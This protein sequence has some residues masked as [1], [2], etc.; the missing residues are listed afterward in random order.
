MECGIIS[1]SVPDG[2][3]GTKTVKGWQEEIG[4]LF[5]NYDNNIN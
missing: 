1:I 3:M 2:E 4:K 5:K